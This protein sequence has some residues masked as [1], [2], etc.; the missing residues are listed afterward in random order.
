MVEKRII[1]YRSAISR[2][3]MGGR[4]KPDI[5]L[6]DLAKTL[7]GNANLS[8]IEICN[9]LKISRSTLYRYLKY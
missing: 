7:Y 3:G 8:L 5:K 1:Q 4:P 2:K 9:S 6:I